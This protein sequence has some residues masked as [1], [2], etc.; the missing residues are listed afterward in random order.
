MVH[1]EQIDDTILF[2]NLL[3]GNKFEILTPTNFA[4]N[5]KDKAS[6][7]Y[8]KFKLAICE[9]RREYFPFWIIFFCAWFGWLTE[10]VVAADDD[11]DAKVG[12]PTTSREREECQDWAV[13]RRRSFVCCGGPTAAAL[14]ILD[15]HTI[16]LSFRV[17]FYSKPLTSLSRFVGLLLV[18]CLNWQFYKAK[19]F[20]DPFLWRMFQLRKLHGNSTGTLLARQ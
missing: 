11:D 6:F 15:A 18:K 12:W 9:I 4:I 17:D 5:E 13:R 8:N 16:S 7:C 10:S 14:N 3:I 1:A 2:F 20:I 19:E